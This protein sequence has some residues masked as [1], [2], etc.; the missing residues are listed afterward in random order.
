MSGRRR[1]PA[2]YMKLEILGIS[3][4]FVEK[5]AWGKRGKCVCVWGGG[6]GGAG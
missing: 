5:E 2:N 6:A 1:N 3:G 4:C